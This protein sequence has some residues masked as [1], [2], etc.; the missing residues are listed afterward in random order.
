MS[1]WVHTHTHTPTHTHTHTATHPRRA[2]AAE[3]RNAALGGGWQPIHATSGG[4]G[5]QAKHATLRSEVGGN[6]YTPLRAPFLHF[7]CGRTRCF[8]F[9]AFPFLACSFSVFPAVGSFKGGAAAVSAYRDRSETLIRAFFFSF[10]CSKLIFHTQ[11]RRIR[12]VNGT[13]SYSDMVSDWVGC[14]CQPRA[15]VSG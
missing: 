3:T 12:I 2:V 7:G 15:G 9:I 8:L 13:T 5:L 1:E 11:K 4:G 10:F 14:L 6:R